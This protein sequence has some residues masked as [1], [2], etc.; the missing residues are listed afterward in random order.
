MDLERRRISDDEG[1]S[2]LYLHSPLLV[3]DLEEE[4][5]GK[6][7]GGGVVY[8]DGDGD[9]NGSGENPDDH[10][11]NRDE[12]D[13]EDV[14]DVNAMAYFR[15]NKAVDT[16]RDSAVLVGPPPPRARPGRATLTRKRS[17]SVGAQI[18]SS[19]SSRTASQFSIGGDS[20]LDAYFNFSNGD[21][22]NSPPP[23]GH[24]AGASRGLNRTASTASTVTMGV[25]ESVRCSMMTIG[26][27]M[28][29]MSES[30]SVMMPI[31]TV[32]LG[33]PFELE[34]DPGIDHV[35]VLINTIQE[36]PVDFFNNEDLDPGQDDLDFD[37]DKRM[38][39]PEQADDSEPNTPTSIAGYASSLASF[40]PSESSTF[41]NNTTTTLSNT[42][43]N[44][45]TV[46]AVCG[47]HIVALRVD[48]GAKVSSSISSTPAP[49]PFSDVC[50][51]LRA[52]FA[53]E[54]VSLAPRFAL[55]YRPAMN[56]RVQELRTGEKSKPRGGSSGGR[57][58]S[59]SVSSVTHNGSGVGA[60]LDPSALRIIFGQQDWEE[61][62]RAVP[63][64]SKLTLHVLNG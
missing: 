19:L 50:T 32:P 37:D 44:A 43:A 10:D 64:G 38:Y 48:R 18:S 30:E 4:K 21:T 60:P 51:R 61:A 55:A 15:D 40:A 23:R 5:E 62:V 7:R 8:G 9:G 25:P 57:A 28:S 3:A 36:R 14:M 49:T 42:P 63:Q 46:K 33:I 16:T 39:R 34:S 24:G 13:M 29:A 27:V 58:R 47:E 26:S 11:E 22:L 53:G 45:L 12:N 1:S 6:K 35:P 52:K 20:L 31:S 17:S 41:T 56:A 59:S 2:A 54:G